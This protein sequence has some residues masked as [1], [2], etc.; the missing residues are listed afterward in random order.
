[1][2]VDPDNGVRCRDHSTPSH[3]TKSEKYAYYDELQSFIDRGQSVVAYHHADRT[4][5]VD[6]QAQY[7]LID[8]EG[9]LGIA[10]LAAF[11]ASRHSVCFFLVLP[12]DEHRE[13]PR[14][15][16]ERL[17][18]SPWGRELTIHLW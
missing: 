6:M 9:E 17:E 15:R 7:R 11:Q 1:M 10:P 16:L 8:A 4:A 2:F 12:V 5:T 14:Q 13:V 18:R 3:R